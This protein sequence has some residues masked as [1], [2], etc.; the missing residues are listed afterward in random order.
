MKSIYWRRFQESLINIQQYII[1]WYIFSAC[2]MISSFA[3]RNFTNQLCEF[4]FHKCNSSS[5]SNFVN[6]SYNSWPLQ[7]IR[8]CFKQFLQSVKFISDNCF[9]FLLFLVT[10]I[11]E[12]YVSCDWFTAFSKICCHGFNH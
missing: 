5:F 2:Y 7:T 6:G 9:W 1:H 4:I 8:N 11:Y 10:D 3:M 12:N